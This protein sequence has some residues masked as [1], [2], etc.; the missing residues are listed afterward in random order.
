MLPIYVSVLNWFLFLDASNENYQ[1]M[2]FQE[3][4]YS[5]IPLHTML[6]NKL[7]V[8]GGVC[9]FCFKKIIIIKI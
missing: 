8:I 2:I 4:I 7:F 3:K 1:I 5:G 6:H 9:L